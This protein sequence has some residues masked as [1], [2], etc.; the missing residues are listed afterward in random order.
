M[1]TPTI[2]R[3]LLLN[4]FSNSMNQGISSAHGPHQVAQK[5]KTTTFPRRSLNLN[6]FPSPSLRVK[7]GAGFRS[8][9]AFDCSCRAS[10][11]AAGLLQADE[12]PRKVSRAAQDESK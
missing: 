4:C 9:V 12:M 5:F 6:A 10:E 8:P 3:P 7:S 1:E 11:L 2:S